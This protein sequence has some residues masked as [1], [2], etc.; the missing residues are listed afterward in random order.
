MQRELAYRVCYKKLID[1]EDGAFIFDY[2]EFD[3]YKDAL[4]FVEIL[5]Q[6]DG[7][8]NLSGVVNFFRDVTIE[9]GNGI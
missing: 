8:K 5:N 7:N 4:D 9:E 1:K 6:C 3:D 2:A